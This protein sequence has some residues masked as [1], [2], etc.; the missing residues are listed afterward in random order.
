MKSFVTYEYCTFTPGPNL[1][2]IIGPNGT[3]K[4]TIV[5]AIALGLGW[6]TNV[7]GRAKD[8]SEF[9][10]H[11]AEKGWIE[12]VLYNAKGPN[13]VIKR[14][15]N[16]NNNTSIWKINGEQKTQKDVIKKVQSFNIQ[17]DNLCQFL[18]QDRVSEFAQLSSQE[19]L[20]ETQRA[21]GGE[22][23]VAVHQKLIELW[24]EHKAIAG[25]MKGDLA[26]IEA[27]EKRNAVMEKDVLRLQ[28]HKAALRKIKMLEIWRLYALYGEAKEEYNSIKEQRRIAMAEYKQLESELKPLENRQARAE[29]TEEEETARKIETERKYQKRVRDLK[30]KE[31][32]IDAEEGKTEELRKDLGRIQLKARK[33][34]EAIDNLKR[35]ISDLEEKIRSAKTDEELRTERENIMRRMNQVKSEQEEIRDKIEM[36]QQRQKEIVDECKGYNAQVNEKTRSLNQLDDIRHRRLDRLR[37]MDPDVYKAVLWLRENT[38]NFQKKVFEPVCLEI[39]VK[40]S[41]SR[42]VD[43]VENLLQNYLKT[44]FCQ[45]REDY[46]YITRELLDKQRL[47]VDVI[48]PVARDLDIDNFKPPVPHHQIERF[49]FECYAL[50]AVEGPPTLL[51][52]LCSKTQLHQVP[53]TGR[54]NLDFEGIARSRQF[55][56]YL[57]SSALYVITYS[58]YTKEALDTKRTLRPARV[59]TTSV[60]HDLRNRLVHEIDEIRSKLEAAEKSVQQLQKED[61][62]WRI[63]FDVLE[64]ERRRLEEQRR[65]LVDANKK[66]AQNKLTLDRLNDS[67][68][69]K[70]NEMSSEE[71]ELQIREQMKERTLK[72]TQLV[73]EHHTIAKELSSLFSQLT[74]YTLAR[75][76]AHAMVQ[77]IK[78][79]CNEH[80]REMKEAKEHYQD[81]DKQYDDIKKKAKDI[82]D[83]AKA[84]YNALE[85]DEATE[86]QVLAKGW[87][88]E[89][90]ENELESERAKTSSTYTP[91][92][93]VME[94]YE[95]RQE[96]IK[97][98]RSKVENKQKRLDK[99]AADIARTRERWYA[100]LKEVVNMISS[101]FSKAF[102]R[103]G[104]AGEVKLHE[105]EDYD[106]W[107][108]DI[109]VKFRDAERLQ[110]L[111]GQRQ[112]GGE[113]SVSTI[114]YLMTLQ[115]LSNVSFRVV[116]EIN[117]G[118][119]PRNE[120]L[121]H[122]QLVEKA[123]TEKT[124]QYFLITPK[125]LPNLDYHERMR[126]LCIF[127]GEWLEDGVNKYRT[128]IDRQ[129]TA[130]ANGTNKARRL[131]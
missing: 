75:L 102:E 33:R 128:Y 126:V 7:L 88:L 101:E 127:N 81:L 20:R 97:N 62:P 47:R 16:K 84:D 130:N 59:L 100:N 38:Q 89:K 93:S 95:Q 29:A 66:T 41:H 113:R 48:A 31:A 28:Q 19:L 36:I 98:A 107:G 125:L 64:T 131:A 35:Q 96:E 49:G 122:K 45:T 17:V 117:Q 8:V 69:S 129:R 24:N 116:D 103:I 14:H 26:S 44:I 18:P 53:I 43:P 78:A 25:S 46:N 106:K 121:V 110:K 80:A 2:M 82:L 11:G 3:G 118:M 30:A 10:K 104:C 111:T 119:D 23:M 52:A 27:N 87:S 51:A 15:I 22:E 58:K 76:Q 67:L 1:N 124:S 57:T 123:C 63:K 114:M 71:E 40:K 12:I 56:R 83:R 55:K 32:L 5:C 13:V 60:D 73:I 112:S 85:A 109:L 115:S 99:I 77:A 42:F 70:E 108:I 6:N 21:V 91:N 86:F 120:R 39:N 92:M 65:E 34:R 61:G 9:V 72:R 50:E 94:K 105:V 79:E 74:R 4:S 37:Q 54:N 90:I 68:R